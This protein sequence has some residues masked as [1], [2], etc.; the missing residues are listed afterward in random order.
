MCERKLG[1]L[2][3]LMLSVMSECKLGQLWLFMLTAMSECKLGQLWVLMMT[4]TCVWPLT[5]PTGE[6]LDAHLIQNTDGDYRVEW[7]PKEPGMHV[8]WSS[9]FHSQQGGKRSPSL[10]NRTESKKWFWKTCF[11]FSLLV[12]RLLLGGRSGVGGEGGGPNNVAL[13][14]KKSNT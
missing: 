11:G 13:L 6:Q 8:L 9:G 14:M 1:Q 7:M 5:A 10:E 3:L 4:V 12:W 2:W